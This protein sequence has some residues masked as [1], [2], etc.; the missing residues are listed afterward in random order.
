[1]VQ[2]MLFSS[3]IHN[4][5]LQNPSIILSTTTS[6]KAMDITYLNLPT[7]SHQ[8]SPPQIPHMTAM[9]RKNPNPSPA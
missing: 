2:F 4:Q 8:P 3:T 6:Q 7:Y 9:N 5:L 1:M